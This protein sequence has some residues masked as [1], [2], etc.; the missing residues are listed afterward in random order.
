MVHLGVKVLNKQSF[1]NSCLA[2]G[3]LLL[4]YLGNASITSGR[5]LGTKLVEHPSITVIRVRVTFPLQLHL[6]F[7]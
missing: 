3:R 4:R 1:S 6:L 7:P 5:K 2:E